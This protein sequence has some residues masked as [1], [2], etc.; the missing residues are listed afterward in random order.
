MPTETGDDNKAYCKGYYQRLKQDPDKWKA[1][2]DKRAQYKRAKKPVN[3]AGT[4]EPRTTKP[5]NPREPQQQ[6]PVNPPRRPDPRITLDNSA[7]DLP[8]LPFET[9]AELAERRN[10]QWYQDN[11]LALA[12]L[13]VKLPEHKDT[14]HD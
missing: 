1:F 6:E 3:P 9:T 12:A 13:G 7:S 10:Y 2:L 8:R 11:E 5:V 4:C 14:K